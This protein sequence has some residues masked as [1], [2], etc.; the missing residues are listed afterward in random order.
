MAIHVI[1]LRTVQPSQITDIRVYPYTTESLENDSIFLYS[2][3]ILFLGA[4]RLN[5]CLGSND[6][7]IACWKK[8]QKN[9]MILRSSNHRFIWITLSRISAIFQ[10]WPLTGW[11]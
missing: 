10:R 8:W 3:K 1:W 2:K 4:T 6:G 7:I 9:S 5:L 11:F